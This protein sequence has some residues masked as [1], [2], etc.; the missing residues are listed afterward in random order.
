MM[1]MVTA[2]RDTYDV[3]CGVEVAG[4]FDDT[5]KAYEAKLRVEKWMEENEYEDYKV[6][7]SRVSVNNIAWYEIDEDI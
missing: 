2:I 5:E 1:Y 4:V 3:E 7:V 6:F